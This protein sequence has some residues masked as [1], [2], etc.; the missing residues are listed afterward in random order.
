MEPFQGWS[1]KGSVK[2]RERRSKEDTWWWNEE[3][4]EAVS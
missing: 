2:K 4:I 3:V 1:F